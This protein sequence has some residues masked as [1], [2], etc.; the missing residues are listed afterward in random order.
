MYINIL[1]TKNFTFFGAGFTQ[2]QAANGL[3]VA[4]ADHAKKYQ[5]KVEHGTQL[6]D[7]GD[8][9][10]IQF[11]LGRGA[12]E[13]NTAEI[14]SALDDTLDD[15]PLVIN[16]FQPS[17]TP[18]GN[19]AEAV[20]TLAGLNDVLSH[21]EQARVAFRAFQD[22]TLKMGVLADI[23]DELCESMDVNITGK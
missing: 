4:W 3:H 11:P 18:T 19:S 1:E 6:I 9:N 7:A 23:M 5:A 14:N 10:T 15:I 17:G 13:H 2:S 12:S 20:A 22:G 21:A 8:Y 16:T